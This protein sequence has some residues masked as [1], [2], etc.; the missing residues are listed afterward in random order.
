MFDFDGEILTASAIQQAHNM[1]VKTAISSWFDFSDLE[2]M[3][4][5]NR[6]NLKTMCFELEVTI[7]PNHRK[8]M[9]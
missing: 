6:N 2:A 7:V 3:D 9:C 8:P 1:L 5:S 4:E